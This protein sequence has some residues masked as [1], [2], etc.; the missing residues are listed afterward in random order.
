MRIKRKAEQNLPVLPKSKRFCRARRGQTMTEYAL[1]LAAI[2]IA[3]F[4]S[5]VSLGQEID[6][7]T[8]WQVD[9]DLTSAS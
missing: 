4:V 3:V 6:H 1:V 2:A 9:A 5:Y 8:S 7:F